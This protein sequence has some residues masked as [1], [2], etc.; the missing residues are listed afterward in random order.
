MK[1]P[2]GTTLTTFMVG[3]ALDPDRFSEFVVDPEAAAE[4]AGLSKEDRAILLC[5]DQNR[6]YAALERQR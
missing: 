2:T 5:G 1:Q 3:L 4:K 6:I